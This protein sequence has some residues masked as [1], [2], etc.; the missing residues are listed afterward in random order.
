MKTYIAEVTI[1]TT[2]R[3][4]VLANSEEEALAVAREMIEENGISYQACDEWSWDGDI[5]VDR[6]IQEVKKGSEDFERFQ[7]YAENNQEELE[8]N[9]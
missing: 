4:P 9:R 1:T 7:A 8:L 6:I 2:D 3:V 5:K